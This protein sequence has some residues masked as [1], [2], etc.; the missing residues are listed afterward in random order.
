MAFRTAFNTIMTR[1]NT[2]MNSTR[3]N[4]PIAWPNI[5]FDPTV[6][7]NAASHQGWAR[8]TILAGDQNQ[9]SINGSSTLWR[10]TGVITV[11]V[12]TPTEKGA[13]MGLSIADDVAAIFRGLTVSGV[14][15]KAGSVVP[16]G[17][18]DEEPF[19]QV[20]VD[21]PFRYDTNS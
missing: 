9:A 1:F 13:E 7:F 12:F 16:I 20:N 10:Q 17:R 3:P 21:V 6:N 14:V 11:Q 2:Q 18:E 8:I 15:M 5:D 19:Y 4:V